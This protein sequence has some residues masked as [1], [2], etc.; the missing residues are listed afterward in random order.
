M[1]F[2]LSA[3][4]STDMYSSWVAAFEKLLARC[5]RRR[6]FKK[7][8]GHQAVRRKHAM[9][10]SVIST[11]S[12]KGK[13]QRAIAK[14]Y[15]TKLVEVELS[16][17]TRARAD[18]MK[19]ASDNLSIDEKFS[20]TGY[21]KVKTAANKGTRKEQTLSSVV[22]ENGVEVD[23]V[24]AITEAYLE[25]FE[26]RLSNR[27][28][29]D[30]WEKYTEETNKVVRTW[31]LGESKSS[32]PF[33]LEELDK[34]IRTLK[35]DSAPGV[36]KYP[37][38]LFS[39]AGKGVR[40]SML[41]LCNRIKETKDIPEQW[42]L[43]KIVSIY[44]QKG[45]KK[46]LKFYRGIFLAILISKVFEKLVK[47]RIEGNLNNTNILQAGSRKKRGP[48]DNVFL[49]RGVIDHFKFTKKPLYITA[50][51][52]EQAFD[53]M[54]LEDCI[55]SLKEIGVEKEYLQHIYKVLQIY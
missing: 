2:D 37:P 39:K 46:K 44:K 42:D 8:N 55:V 26:N 24:K 28:P 32:S 13:T 35:D 30:G 20:P 33:T 53:S 25:E 18:R 36:D 15:Q 12:K 4:N 3:L 49:F 47:N 29:A 7:G 5:F 34:V 38:K 23:G 17:S 41:K 51:D 1:E 9:V 10:R 14:V 50:Y 52:F 6:T 54:W 27:K 19:K 16:K 21:W 11:V 48:P 31:L 45:S 22:K 43:V 40:M